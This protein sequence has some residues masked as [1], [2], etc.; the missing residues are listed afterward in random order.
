M[1]SNKASLV[2][3]LGW[4]INDID[5]LIEFAKKSLDSYLK[6]ENEESPEGE[7][8]LSNCASYIENVQGSLDLVGAHGAAMLAKEIFILADEFH[9][10]KIEKVEDAKQAL[11]DA[12]IR[13]PE[14]LNHL[15]E[16][17]ADLPVIILPLLNDL[18]SA[19]NAELLSE[20]LVFLPDN[21]VINNDDIGIH[22]YVALDKENLQKAC[23]RLRYHFQKSLLG[24]FKE[25]E[26][27][28]SLQTLQRVAKNLIRLNNNIRLRSL[29]WIIIA[30]AEALEHDK[31]D[32]SITVKLLM[33][34]MEREIRL[35][36]ELQEDAHN[37]SIPDELIKN[38][39]YYVGLAEKGCPTLDTVKEAYVLDMHLPQGETLEELRNYYNAPGR[40]LWKSV[41]DSLNEQ[42]SIL[43]KHIETMDMDNKVAFDEQLTTLSESLYKLIGSLRVIG[44]NQASNII[45]ELDKQLVQANDESSLNHYV[46]EKEDLLNTTEQL[47]KLQQVL[48]EYAKTGDDITDIAFSD[49]RHLDMVVVRQTQ[50]A[51]IEDIQS[52]QQSLAA[53]IDKP[54]AF[55]ELDHALQYLNYIKGALVLLNHTDF[56]PLVNSIKIYVQE[57]L[58]KSRHKPIDAEQIHLADALTILETSIK[59]SQ[60]NE[61]YTDLLQTAYVAI[62]DLSQYSK[63][64]PLLD[65]KQ[66]NKIN[67]QLEQKKKQFQKIPPAIL[68]KI[69]L[70]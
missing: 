22:D 8:G 34:R 52:T 32:S 53:F 4:V 62:D 30:L 9:R 41:A 43:I 66:R 29:W 69:S 65:I 50:D 51:I 55:P 21:G 36:G 24:W 5:P 18:R 63:M 19:R 47:L 25:E 45:A 16:G 6:W 3:R 20:H 37:Q 11:V 38:L 61:D 42:I 2:T 40:D 48:A 56:I 26:K 15:E 35:L 49:N 31:L 58:K 17:Y 57:D 23:V 28:G 13:L 7:D 68:K 59:M 10:G 70:L 46:L 67:K 27:Q 60:E 12:F 39:L 44:L 33:G 14:Y 54:T 64:N 1:I